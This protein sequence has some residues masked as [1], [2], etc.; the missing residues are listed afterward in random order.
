ME[1]ARTLYICYF[2]I[3]EPLVQTQVLPYLREIRK[4]GIEVSILTFEPQPGEWEAE[5]RRSLSEEGIDWHSLK[6]HKRPSIPATL[7]DIANGLRKINS[8]ARSKK[9]DVYHARGHLP[10]PMAALAKTLR[11]GKFLFDIRGFLPEEYV[12]AGVWRSDG[13][14]Y[15]VFKRLEKWLE[16]KSDGFVVLTERARELRFP[17]AVADGRDSQGRPVEVIPCCVN[18]SHY[19]IDRPRVR[20]EM[21]DALGIGGKYVVAYVGS[22]DGWYLSAE[23]FD[24]FEALKREVPDSFALILTQR[25]QQRVSDE[26]AARGFSSDEF[27]VTGVPPAEVARYLAASDASLSFIKP[28]YSKQSSSPTKIAEY[29]AAG[30]PVIS[31]AGVGDVDQL[32]QNN[33]VGVL[34]EEFTADAYADAIR[35]TIELGDISEICRQ[36]AAREFD[37]ETVGGVRYRRLYDSILSTE[38]K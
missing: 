8:L 7:F 30:L 16:K 22:F 17:S 25:D 32:I 2:G 18:F 6:Y 34:V 23:M 31:N 5:L 20:R 15:R 12:D 13:A 9:I 29:L 36:V 21:R 14:V 35:R 1:R 27:L 4:G 37:L 11:G 19:A 24:F 26:L 38:S 3:R 33:C 10:A 28:S